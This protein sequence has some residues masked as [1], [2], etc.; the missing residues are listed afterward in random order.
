MLVGRSVV[1]T[2]CA[3]TQRR[4]PFSSLIVYSTMLTGGILVATCSRQQYQ[5]KA[6]PWLRTA[7]ARACVPILAQSGTILDEEGGM[8]LMS[9]GIPATNQSWRRSSHVNVSSQV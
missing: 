4:P 8:R 1:S 5:P 2:S 7:P 9:L 6:L 3:G